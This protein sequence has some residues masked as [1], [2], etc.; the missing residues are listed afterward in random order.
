MKNSKYSI[1]L[2]YYS[3]FFLILG[4]VYAY[5]VSLS[6]G[7]L[8]EY[9]GKIQT[10]DSGSTNLCGFNPLIVGTYEYQ[11]KNQFSL[12]PEI[13]FTIPKSGRDSYINKMSLFAV[14]NGKY[15]LSNY[16]FIAGVGLFFTRLSSSGGNEELRN[17]TGTASFPLANGVVFSRN[18]IL[19]FGVGHDFNKDWSVDCQIFLFN[20]LHKEDR[21]VSVAF[22]GIYHFGEL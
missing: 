10:D 15:H 8:C 11:L 2:F 4:K 1:V 20:A 3:C 6:V 14:A 17:G 7:N 13:G 21:S 5:D 22:K 16:H 12:A 19:N 9:V 18:F